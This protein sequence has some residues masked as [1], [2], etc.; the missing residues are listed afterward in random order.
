MSKLERML[1]VH[2]LADKTIVTIDTFG[3]DY[4]MVSSR[5]KK[6]RNPTLSS[7]NRI[8]R[9]LGRANSV[10]HYLK[11]GSLVIAAWFNERR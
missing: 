1:L 10:F 9:L 11:P 6:Y 7:C 2:R 8:T 4:D 5:S 3:R